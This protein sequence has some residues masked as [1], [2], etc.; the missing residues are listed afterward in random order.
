LKTPRTIKTWIRCCV[1]L[2][3]ALIL[4]VTR[5]SLN[6]MGQAGFFV[7][8]VACML[9]PTLALS[10][11]IL[12]AITLLL[13]MCVGWAWGAAA[14][15]AGLS[16]RNQA[17]LAQ[18]QQR[19]Q[20]SIVNNG[21]PATVQYQIFIFKGYFLDPGVSAVWGAFF[22]I[23]TFALGTLRAYVPKLALLSI[24]GSIVLDV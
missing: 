10:L 16:V 18:Q 17:L 3:A 24:F 14:M 21:I 4:M 1:A 19:V 20:A 2:A 6:N 11:F 13:G 7:A 22:F 12:A 9:P 5:R 15:A 8:I 23:G